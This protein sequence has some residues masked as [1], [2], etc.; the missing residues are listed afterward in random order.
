MIFKISKD[1]QLLAK[2]LLSILIVLE[3]DWYSWYTVASSLYYDVVHAY[4]QLVKSANLSC[5]V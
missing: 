2:T 5:Q 4:Q 3:V 1:P